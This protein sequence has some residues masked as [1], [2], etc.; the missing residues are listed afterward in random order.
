M[1]FEI[2]IKPHTHTWTHTH[3]HIH[4]I[5]K[6]IYKSI[7]NIIKDIF[8]YEEYGIAVVLLLSLIFMVYF[9]F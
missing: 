1:I 4:I 7:L 2:H 9:G 6:Y 3:I 8:I 5:Y